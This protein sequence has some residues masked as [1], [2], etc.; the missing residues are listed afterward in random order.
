MTVGNHISQVVSKC[1]LGHANWLDVG[2]ALGGRAAINKTNDV[3]SQF[4]RLDFWRRAQCSRSVSAASLLLSLN[5]SL[6]NRGVQTLDIS[7]TG[8]GG[9]S[10]QPRRDAVTVSSSGAIYSGGT[11]CG[12]KGPL[13]ANLTGGQAYWL[14]GVCT[15]CPPVGTVLNMGD[16]LTW[17]SDSDSV[18]SDMSKCAPDEPPIS[19]DMAGWQLCFL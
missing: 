19:T 16:T 4:S 9:P 17:A 6:I 8:C 10:W 7:A 1:C 3:Q 12:P 14:A 11:G 15:G 2:A 13:A 5:E 18:L